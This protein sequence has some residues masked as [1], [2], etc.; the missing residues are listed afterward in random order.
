MSYMTRNDKRGRSLGSN[1]DEG[2]NK[3]KNNI[4]KV[5]LIA[6]LFVSVAIWVNF[7][8]LGKATGATGSVVKHGFGVILLQPFYTLWAIFYLLTSP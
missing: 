3:A 5:M 1:I 8:A 4:M 6:V 7:K 2:V